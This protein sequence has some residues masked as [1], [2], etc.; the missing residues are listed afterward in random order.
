[1]KWAEGGKGLPADQN[2]VTF[3]NYGI[4]KPAHFPELL[5]KHGLASMVKD[6]KMLAS[7]STPE[8]LSALQKELGELYYKRHSA[9]VV[10]DT[11]GDPFKD[12][13]G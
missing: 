5:E 3:S 11:V 8:S 6:A 10:G 12:T 4:K 1:M 2:G 13:S 7:Y 9:T